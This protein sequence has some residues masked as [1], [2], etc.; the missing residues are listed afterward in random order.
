MQTTDPDAPVCDEYK[1]VAHES[2]PEEP[3]LGSYFPGPQ[4]EHSRAPVFGWNFPPAHSVQL[5]TL[6]VENDPVEQLVHENCPD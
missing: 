6:D 4:L 2:Q 1:P 3:R 5:A